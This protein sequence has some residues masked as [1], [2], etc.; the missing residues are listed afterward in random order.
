MCSLLCSD[1]EDNPLNAKLAKPV[2]SFCPYPSNY[3]RDDQ[4][5]KE[6]IMMVFKKQNEVASKSL[7]GLRK[8]GG[9]EP[10]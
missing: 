4:I 10:D 2:T 6:V 5:K 7:F 1:T 3:N 8:F 9:S